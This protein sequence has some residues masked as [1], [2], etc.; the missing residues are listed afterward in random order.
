MFVVRWILGRI[1][2]LLNA[3]TAPKRAQRPAEVQLKL[4]QSMARYSLYQYDACPFCVKVRRALRRNNFNIELRDAKQEPH[5]SE[6]QSGGGRLM[7]PCLRIEENGEVRW[8]Y[9]SGDI[10]AYLEDQ[11]GDQPKAA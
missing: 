4:D 10:I 3:L 7:V 8:M 9:E 6:L 2:L 1:V 11:Y 5:R